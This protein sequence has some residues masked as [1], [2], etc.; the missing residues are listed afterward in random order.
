MASLSRAATNG[1]RSLQF[2]DPVSKKR[3]TLRLGGMTSR[4]A[5][6]FRMKIERLVYCRQAGTTPE[7]DVANWVAQLAPRF[8]DKLAEWGL[9]QPRVDH[10][11]PALASFLDGYFAKRT[12][13]K[14]ATQIVYKRVR[15]YLVTYFGADRAL[16][17]ITP[18]DADDWAL[19]LQHE[20]LAENT[21]RRASG[22]AR[23]FFKVAIR[24][25]LITDNPFQDLKASIVANAGRYYFLTPEDTLLLLDACPSAEWRLI[26]ALAR[27]AGLRTPSETFALKWQDVDWAR[28]RIT[29]HSPKTEH[30]AGHESREIPIFPELR[31]YLEAA[32]DQ[33]EP[34]AVH[35]VVSYRDATQNLRTQF[36]RIIKRAGLKPWPKLFQNLRSS[37][38]TELAEKFPIQVVTSWIGNSEA[39]AKKHYLQ[40]TD[41]HFNRGVAEPCSA[42]QNALQYM[43]MSTEAG[44]Q[45]GSQRVEVTS[46]IDSVRHCTI[47]SVGGTGLEPVTPSV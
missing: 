8:A 47:C 30:H 35:P 28:S 46:V 16:H 20:G 13:V 26:I 45:P 1:T 22:I 37:R 23:Q 43:S 9:I 40:V 25:K 15:R 31:P 33:A 27:F 42:L 34:G 32:R 38:E 39:V 7:A 44:S 6:S 14:P 19:F 17:T 18:G 2:V 4:E 12:D 24:H 29:V 5:E 36:E 41:A 11:S 3:R 21:I 10:S